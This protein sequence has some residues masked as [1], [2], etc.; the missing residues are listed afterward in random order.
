MCTKE[1]R[2]GDRV[3]NSINKNESTVVPAYDPKTDKE[4]P[5]RLCVKGDDG[6]IYALKRSIWILIKQSS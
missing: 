4:L 6:K 1:Y 5:G 3:Q 2:E